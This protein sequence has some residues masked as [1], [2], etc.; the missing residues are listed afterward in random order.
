M[1]FFSGATINNERAFGLH[2]QV[3]TVQVGKKANLLIVKSNPFNTI[4]AYDQIQTVIING[5]ALVRET[6]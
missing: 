2:N 6:L 1:L 4:E 3:G 5:R